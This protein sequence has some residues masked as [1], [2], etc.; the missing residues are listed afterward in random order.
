MCRREKQVARERQRQCNKKAATCATGEQQQALVL[1]L[2]GRD[3][4]LSAAAA[5][6]RARELLVSGP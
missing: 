2:V 1:K 4:S 5:K 6:Q 3:F